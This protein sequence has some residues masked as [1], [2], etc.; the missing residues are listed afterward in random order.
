MRLLVALDH[1]RRQFSPQHRAVA[2]AL[3]ADPNRRLGA[4]CELS[5]VR[6]LSLAEP[7]GN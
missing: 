1:Q 2:A 4:A 5:Q 6:L 3:Q 7:D